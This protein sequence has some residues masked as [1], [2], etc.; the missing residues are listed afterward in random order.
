LACAEG[1]H[2]GVPSSFVLRDV[3]ILGDE[4]LEDSDEVLDEDSDVDVFEEV[5]DESSSDE[6]DDDAEDDRQCVV[7]VLLVAFGC[8]T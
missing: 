7:V 4:L 8:L 5:D 1:I 3:E 2:A 6:L